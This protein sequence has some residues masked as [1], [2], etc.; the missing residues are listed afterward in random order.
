MSETSA[1]S[2]AIKC[3]TRRNFLES[4]AVLGGIAA[5]GTSAENVSLASDM[6]SA[7]KDIDWEDEA[8]VVILGTGAAGLSA[9][10]TIGDEALGSAVILEAAPEEE[11]GGNSRVCGQGV[12]CPTSVEGAL[13]YQTDLNGAYSVEPELMQAWAENICENIEWLTNTV[14]FNAVEMG[15]A[16][17]PEAASSDTVVWYAHSGGGPDAATWRL[18]MDAAQEYG[19]KIYYETRGIDLI[20]NLD[21]EVI[22]VTS[23]DGRHFKANKGVI[24][25]CGGFENNP[26]LVNMYAPIGMWGIKPNGTW[27]NRGDGIAMCEKLGAQMWHMNNFS[28]NRCSLQIVAHDDMVHLTQA[29]FGSHHD[30]IILGPDGKRFIYEEKLGQAR[31]GKLFRAGTWQNATL[32]PEMFMLFNQETYDAKAIF[33]TSS[34]SS[35][36]PSVGVLGSNDDLLQAGIIRQCETEADI[37]AFTGLDE[38]VIKESLN[39]YNS[40]ADNNNDIEFHRGVASYDEGMALSH[41]NSNTSGYVNTAVQASIEAFDL[42]HITLPCYVVKLFPAILNTQGGAKRGTSGEVLRRDGSAIPRLFAAGEFGTVYSYKYNLGGNFSE[43]ISSGRLA[44]RSVSKLEPW[45]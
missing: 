26:D 14:K 22:G 13:A 7:P 38:A 3:I 17:F 15:T 45:G 39:T 25:A 27:W 8:D 35:R 32:P 42:I 28:G 33:T 18:L 2:S 30:F 12:F 21:G 11:N 36:T 23:E 20:T 1:N 10:V 19:T 31:H 6:A 16:E 24:L 29:S 4:A 40:Y 43:A 37:A 9:A 34:F 5:V 44:A 41:T